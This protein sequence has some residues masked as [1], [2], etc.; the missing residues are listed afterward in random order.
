M[1]ELYEAMYRHV[2]SVRPEVTVGWHIWHNASFNPMFRAEQEFARIA[3]YS[4]YSDFIKPV[5]YNAL[6]GERMISYMDSVRQ[7]MFGDVT[8]AELL[9][10]QYKF[11]ISRKARPARSR[12]RIVG[13]MYIA[14]RRALSAL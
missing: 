3:S 5:I 10:M 14:R 9:E 8:S 13:R 12:H 11:S 7:N 4:G 2:K 6:A 1:R